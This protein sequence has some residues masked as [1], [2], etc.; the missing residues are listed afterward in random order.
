M[1]PRKR[2]RVILFRRLGNRSRFI[3]YLRPLFRF[4]NQLTL[5]EQ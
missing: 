3:D 4:E 1:G 2:M 5:A